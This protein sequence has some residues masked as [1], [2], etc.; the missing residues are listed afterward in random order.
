MA[1]ASIGQRVNV[2][3]DSGTVRYVGATQFAPGEW[4]GVE[5]DHP[6]GRN[7]GAVQGVRYFDCQKAG[8]YGVFVRA[9]FL[10]QRAPEGLNL[11]VPDA[12]VVVNK[13]QVKLKAAVNEIGKCK[14]TIASLQIE[15]ENNKRLRDEL[16]VSL[17]QSTVEL[18][19][20]QAQNGELLQLLESL[21]EQ[22]DHL[23]ADF[24]I[25]NEEL[26][27][28]KALEAAV[29][30]LSPQGPVSSDDFQILLQHNKKLELAITS[31]KGVSEEAQNSRAEILKLLNTKANALTTLEESHSNI[32]EKLK[33]SELIITQLHE[34]LEI[35]AELSL[36]ID[37]L[38]SENEVLQNQVLELTQSVKEL[39]E[40][41]E[42]DKSI[43]ENHALVEKEFQGLVTTLKNEIL[44]HKKQLDKLL[45]VNSLLVKEQNELRKKLRDE[46]L[47]FNAHEFEQLVLES[48]KLKLTDSKT[49]FVNSIIRENLASIS[50]LPPQLVPNKYKDQTMLIVTLQK[51][52]SSCSAIL[53]HLQALS[54][55]S[56]MCQACYSFERLKYA[57]SYMK[58]VIEYAHYNSEKDNEK[59]KDHVYFVSS[60]LD[61]CVSRFVPDDLFSLDFSF[62]TESFEFIKSTCENIV[63]PRSIK[64]HYVYSFLHCE[65]RLAVEILRHILKT[66]PHD[67]STLEGFENNLSDFISK[68]SK[69]VT[70]S[71]EQLDLLKDNLDKDLSEDYSLSQRDVKF[72]PVICDLLKEVESEIG[73]E[74]NELIQKFSDSSINLSEDARTLEGLTDDLLKGFKFEDVSYHAI[75]E[76]VAEISNN[77]ASIDT[78]ATSELEFQLLEKTQLIQNLHLQIELLEKNMIGSLAG[79]ETELKKTEKLLLEVREDYKQLDQ[80]LKDLLL[81]NEDLLAQLDTLRSADHLSEY[82]QIPVFENLK[83]MRDYTSTMSLIDEINLLKRMLARGASHETEAT[84]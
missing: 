32:S 14:E 36:V 9:E 44:S 66:H 15:L 40:L 63:V 46:N 65:V 81:A 68:G 61:D 41:H 43:E 18:E 33:A 54:F 49:K 30:S 77:D 84:C 17:E 64:A 4:V 26:E 35:S 56:S 10:E 48:K 25:V 29:S 79:K 42:I 62:T 28:H 24:S 34:E 31:L 80:Q 13:L 74:E 59:I 76:I 52:L 57:L 55:S 71:A 67:N 60:R 8:N 37:Y 78:E 72:F 22:Y 51:C 73:L 70:I 23:S 16:E 50:A 20:L 2:R 11:I 47:P 27:I 21:R 1:P 58:S 6:R 12:K 69:L 39:T 83:A 7:D 53:S 82:Q 5:L 19:Y 38:T 75:Y 3:G 45:S